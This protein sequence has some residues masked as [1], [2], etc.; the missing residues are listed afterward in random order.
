MPEALQGLRV[1]SVLGVFYRDS[2]ALADEEA[3]HVLMVADES[4]GTMSVEQLLQRFAGDLVQVV[5]HHLPL[6]PHDAARWGGGSCLFE[7][8]GHCPFGHHEHPNLLFTLQASGI[9]RRIDD[10]WEVASDK[11]V[12]RLDLHHLVG[13]RGQLV[14]LRA[15][16]LE[17]IEERMRKVNEGVP[18]EMSLDDLTAKL[19]DARDLLTTIN[20]LKDEIS[21]V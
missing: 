19:H 20:R 17:E 6:E 16:A 1:A 15:P 8:A 5:A 3:P 7:K 18:E 14:V 4:D 2:A 13:H 12:T 9:L 11:G 21:D 10:G